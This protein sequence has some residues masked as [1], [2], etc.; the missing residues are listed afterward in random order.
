MLRPLACL[1]DDPPAWVIEFIDASTATW[2]EIKLREFMLPMDVEVILKIPISH[3]RQRDTW[4][5]HYDRK[6]LFSV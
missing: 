5:W 1:K 3:R 6:G 4:A 2:N